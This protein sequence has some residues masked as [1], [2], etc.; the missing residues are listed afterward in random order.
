VFLGESEDKGKDLLRQVLGKKK[1]LLGSY[2]K[3]AVGLEFVLPR[4]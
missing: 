1:S 3:A 2:F 4:T